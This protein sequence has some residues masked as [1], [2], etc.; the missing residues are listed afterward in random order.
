METAYFE[1]EK[2]NIFI[3]KEGVH[4]FINNVPVEIIERLRDAKQS[5]Y[6]Y[7]EDG[8]FTYHQVRI[9]IG[10]VIL[11]LNSIEKKRV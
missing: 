8:N 5:K 3:D 11:Q 9:V 1:S 7:A 6:A 10:D 4:I 2:V